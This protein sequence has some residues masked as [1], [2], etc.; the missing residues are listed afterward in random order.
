MSKNEINISTI[1]D[2]YIENIVEE[3]KYRWNN[4]EKK[5]DDKEIFDVIGGII[6]RQTALT[7]NFVKSPNIWNGEIA[8]IFLR[9]MADNYINLA[10]ILKSPKDRAKEFI[11]H[12][13]GQ[14]KLNLE[15]RKKQIESDGKDIESDKLIEH[16]ESFIN[17][18]RY[19]FLTEV[20]LGSWSGKSTRLMAEEADCLDF[21]NYVYQPF[22]SCVHSTW[23]HISRYNVE[24]SDNPLHRFLYKPIILD[25]DPD[26]T[27]LDLAAKYLDKSFKTFDNKFHFRFDK[28]SSYSKLISDL[29]KI[30]NSEDD[31]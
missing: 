17:S 18:Q 19:T 6:S 15:H 23:G 5:L 8:P 26:I 7:I 28:D 13:L 25:F 22:S 30:I 29:D 27:Y 1:I 20:N 9:S 14:L 10:W 2:S 11:L 21:Y 3:Q 12:G 16:E 24:P 4:W 31:K